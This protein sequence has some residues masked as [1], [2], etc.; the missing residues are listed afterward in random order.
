[1]SNC[2]RTPALDGRPTMFHNWPGSFRFALMFS[3]P[4]LA[5]A[6]ILE[7]ANAFDIQL[8]TIGNPGNPADMRYEQGSVPIG[9]GVGSVASPFRMGQT[10][11]TNAQYTAFL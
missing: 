1:M 9:V 11:I 8:V 6:A 4:I 3:R 10:E 5:A 2:Y 7:P